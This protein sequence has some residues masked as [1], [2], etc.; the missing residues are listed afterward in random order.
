MN[1]LRDKEVLVKFGNNLRKL[2]KSKNLTMEE[3]SYET[4]VELSQIYRIEKGKVN[5]TLSTLNALANALDIK[6][7]ELMNF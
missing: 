6:L 3:L 2:R 4:D 7:S 1:K 5:P